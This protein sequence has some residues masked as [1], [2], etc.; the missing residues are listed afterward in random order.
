MCLLLDCN[1]LFSTTGY[2]GGEG[3]TKRMS[4]F[5]YTGSMSKDYVCLDR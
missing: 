2:T 5:P 1:V 3:C 4:S